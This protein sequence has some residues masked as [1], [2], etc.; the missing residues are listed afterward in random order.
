MASKEDNQS[1]GDPDD[2]SF[3]RTEDYICLNCS[4]I[5]QNGINRRMALAAEAFGN[6]MCFLEDIT[7]EVR[8]FPFASI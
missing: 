6:K 8:A 4:V 7:L 2:L 5:T 3:L 1:N